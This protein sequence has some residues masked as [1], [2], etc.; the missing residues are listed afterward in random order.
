MTTQ[1]QRQIQSTQHIGAQLSN[2]NVQLASSGSSGPSQNTVH[3]AQLQVSARATLANTVSIAPPVQNT[4]TKS[5]E[6]KHI[7]ATEQAP[8]AP[9]L[10]P[11]RHKQPAQSNQ[12]IQSTQPALPNHLPHLHRAT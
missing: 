7:S 2:P 12:Y 9:P 1:F 3:Q 5:G 6:T 4:V 8:R 11:Q 10:Q